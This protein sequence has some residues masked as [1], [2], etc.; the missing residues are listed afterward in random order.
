VSRVSQMRKVGL[1]IN[2]GST[3]APTIEIYIS[4]LR[5]CTHKRLNV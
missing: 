1:I 4:T 5:S 3:H 2:N